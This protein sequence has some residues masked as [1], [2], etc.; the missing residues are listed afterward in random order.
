VLTDDE[1]IDIVARE[2][3][4]F[5]AMGPPPDAPFDLV[6]VDPPY[7]TADDDV[8]ELLTALTGPGWLAPGAIVSVER[9]RRNPV[10][11]PPGFTSGWERTFGDTLLTFL[12]V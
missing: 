7:R 9:P 12:F 1:P 6:F 5:V 4:R 3:A 8:T 2:V 10:I 11:A